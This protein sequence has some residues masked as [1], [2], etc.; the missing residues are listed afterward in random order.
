LPPVSTAD[1]FVRLSGCVVMI[2]FSFLM[3]KRYPNRLMVLLPLSTPIW[4]LLSSGYNEYYPF[5]APVFICVLFILFEWKIE[6]IKPV[7]MGLILS[8]VG[9]LYA[10]FLPICFFIL[11]LYT[12]RTGLKS[13]FHACVFSA[14]WVILLIMLFWPGSLPNFIK[15]YISVLNLGDRNSPASE[16][17]K[18]I[19]G[20]PFYK[21]QFAISWDNGKR[22]FFMQFWGGGLSPL[23][24]LLGTVY[25]LFKKHQIGIIKKFVTTQPGGNLNVFVSRFGGPRN[26]NIQ[27]LTGPSNFRNSSYCNPKFRTIGNLR[28]KG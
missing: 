4:V 9:L 26:K 2:G 24:L 12:I 8:S 25:L 14:G 15:N 13:A 3:I 21:T 16:I 28:G 7:Y 18:A 22:L 6:K 1:T 23:V 5:I 27:K 11:W 19:Q 17:G 20:T 10:G